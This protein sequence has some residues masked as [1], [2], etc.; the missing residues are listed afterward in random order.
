MISLLPILIIS[1]A[2]IITQSQEPSKQQQPDIK[3]FYKYDTLQFT[4]DTSTSSRNFISYFEIKNRLQIFPDDF[5]INSSRSNSSSANS[6]QEQVVNELKDFK[7]IS[8]DPRSSS[9]YIG[10][11]DFLL[12]LT[13]QANGSLGLDSDLVQIRPSDELVSECKAAAAAARS[14]TSCSNFIQVVQ[15]E[16]AEGSDEILV[17]G[18]NARKPLCEWRSKRNPREVIESFDGIGKSSHLPSLSSIYLRLENGDYIFATSIDYT[19]SERL[20]FLVDRSLGSSKHVRT[21]Q[22]NSNWLNEP[23]F[24]GSLELGEFVYVF[25]RENAVEFRNCRQRVHSRVVRLCKRDQGFGVFDVWRSFEKATLNCSAFAGGGSGGA[26][27]PQARRP[28]T[29]PFNS[30]Y[31]MDGRSSGS[32]PFYFDEIQH[33]HFDKAK[34]LIYAIF[35]TAL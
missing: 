15:V 34:G 2:I 31:S 30:Y 21:D 5:V 9:V 26:D 6:Q 20:D 24:V 13:L 27:D 7:E 11:R 14:S 23:V 18:T 4:A 1:H 33:V 12:R 25:L 19:Y 3:N 10:A 16:E 22:Y 28:P 8:V 32:D 35:S 29:S 17:C